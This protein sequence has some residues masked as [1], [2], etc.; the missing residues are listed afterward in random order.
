MVRHDFDHEG[1]VNRHLRAVIYV[2]T[3]NRKSTIT[4]K[5]AKDNW[6]KL[7]IFNIFQL[8]RNIKMPYVLL[9]QTNIQST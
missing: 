8:Y 2:K 7:D 4:G 6:V 3:G 1:T 5:L 9:G